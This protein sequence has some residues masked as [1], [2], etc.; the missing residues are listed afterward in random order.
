MI[1]RV[2]N[3]RIQLFDARYKWGYF[4]AFNAGNYCVKKDNQKICI[5]K[6]KFR[7]QIKSLIADA[8]AL[9]KRID[10]GELGYDDLATIIQIYNSYN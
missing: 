3:G 1:P 7:E 6:R 9:I 10:S 5:K 4:G 8:D 2:I